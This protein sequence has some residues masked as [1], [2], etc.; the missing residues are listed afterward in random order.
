MSTEKTALKSLSATVTTV[1]TTTKEG[2]PLMKTRADGSQSPV[3]LCGLK[4]TEGS[5]AGKTLWA[6]RTLVNRDGVAKE[7]VAKGDNVFATLVSVI[8][9]KPFFEVTT[10]ANAS[11][12]DLLSAFGATAETTTT[13]TE[14]KEEVVIPLAKEKAGTI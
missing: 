10:S 9:G 3:A 6:Q 1:I 12:E 11:D 13:S 7:P 2:E 8:N 4:L 14:E 5:H